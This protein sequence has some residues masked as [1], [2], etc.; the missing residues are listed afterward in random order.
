MMKKITLLVSLF[1]SVSSLMAQ[2]ADNSVTVVYPSSFGISRPLSEL[3]DKG[4][5]TESSESHI[6]PD[7]DHRPP[8]HF[9]YSVEKDG[10]AYGNDPSTIQS[11]FDRRSVAIPV[12]TNWAGQGSGQCPPDPSGAAGTNY[13]VQTANANPFKIFNKTT[14]AAVGTV[15]QIQNLWSPAANMCCD[16]VVL[17]DKYADRWVLTAL[18]NSTTIYMAVSTTN[19]PTGTYYTYSFTGASGGYDYDKFSIWQ[20]GY[21][22]TYNGQSKIFVMERDKMIL[23]DAS[24]RLLYKT[25]TPGNGTYTAFWE[26]LPAD[27]DGQL[28]P[29]GTPLPFVS[30]S[31]NAWGSG[32]VDGVKIWTMATTWGTTPAGTV[33]QLATVPTAAFDASYNTSGWY[34]VPQYGGSNRLDGIGG[35]VMYRAQWRKWVGYNTLVLNWGVKITETPRQRGIKW[36]ELRQN[37]TTGVW[38]LYQEGIYCPG[39]TASYWMGSIG[40]DDNGSIALCYAKAD[41]VGAIYPGLA[42]TARLASDPLGTFSF[43]ETVAQAGTSFEPA[44]SCGNRYGDYAQTSLDPD[45]LTFWH[46]GCYV[47][48]GI[49]TRIYSFRVPFPTSVA[50]NGNPA[51]YNVYQNGNMLNVKASNLASKSEMVVDLFDNNGRMIKG[52]MIAPSAGNIETT[53]DITGLAKAPYMVRIGNKDFQKVVKVVVN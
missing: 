42:F 2:E 51:S 45:G 12:L 24:A 8:Q 52:S 17:Y 41:S 18:N 46:T 9:E 47:S 19:D 16:P 27:A 15:R 38:S 6:Y 3:M 21:Y 13:Y 40:M 10:P 34:D 33:T 1:F 37:Q 23:G 4:D 53:I 11:G 5:E 32:N 44:T 7:R 26:A 49:K 31:D 35:V 36:V 43:G 22:M 50:E 29:A 28:P 48:S 30:Y 20:D 25:F 39:A 14:G